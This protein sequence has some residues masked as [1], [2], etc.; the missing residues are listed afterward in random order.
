MHDNVKDNKRVAKN[1]IILYVRMILL[2]AVSL[3]TSRVVLAS[4][5][6]EDFGIYNV[7]GGIVAMFSFINMALANSSSRYI[8][9]SLGKADLNDSKLVFSSVYYAHVLIAAIIVILSET[10]G[11]WFL[12]NKLVIP[13]ARMEAALWV[14]QFS[15]VSCVASILY[16]PYNATIIAH[17]KM[18]AF[19][20]ISII[21]AALKLLIAYIISITSADRL[22]VYALF[23]LGVNILNI[24]IY[25]SYCKKNFD[26]VKR[27]RVKN[28]AKLKEILGFAAWSMVGNLAFVG[29]TQGINILLN[30]FFGPVVNASRGIAIQLQ[31][32]V[33]GFVTN[34]QT[35]VNPQI[36]KSYA[37][38][39][40]ARMHQLIY[41]SS[42]FSFFLLLIIV[43]PISIEAK[44]VLKIWLGNVPE[45]AVQFTILTLLTKLIDTLSNPIGIANNATG[46]IKK[47]QI[48]EGGTLLLI[49]PVSYLFLKCGSSPVSV[50]WVQLLVMYLVQILRLYLVCDRIKMS[51]KEYF[52]KV[53]L[54]ILPVLVLSPILPI[55]LHYYL[56]PSILT[57]I[58][59]MSVSVISVIV[60]IYTLG[61]QRDERQFIHDKISKILKLRGR[62]FNNSTN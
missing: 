20:Y 16:T 47:Y 21:D 56:V 26:E 12:T 58:V 35:A 39:D 14:Y 41:A 57:T 51:K 24:Y 42:K 15:V 34:F 23:Y 37:I 9:Y 52:F 31:G 60:C 13:E 28:L 3:Y 38:G 59:V 11:L 30:L 10:I 46:N 53:L 50:F 54:K 6:V 5:G 18:S 45:Y 27:V 61:L 48:C 4:L 44:T 29:Y 62:L 17:E 33:I 40:Y 25:K 1:M 36:T 32:A 7:V 22:I 43:L 8:T 19:A 2:L 55:L 49:V